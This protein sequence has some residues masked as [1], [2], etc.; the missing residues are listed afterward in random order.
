[1]MMETHGEQEDRRRE[2]REE[3]EETRGAEADS[4]VLW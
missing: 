1:M 3:V 2:E 4:D